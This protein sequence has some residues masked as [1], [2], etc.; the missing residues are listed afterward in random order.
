MDPTKQ[1]EA[2]VAACLRC[3]DCITKVEVA[4]LIANQYLDPDAVLRD[5]GDNAKVAALVE[6]A[7]AVRQA[8]EDAERKANEKTQES[9]GT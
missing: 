7:R 8:K 1:Q 6:Q 9:Q 5:M 4:A 3:V 2:V